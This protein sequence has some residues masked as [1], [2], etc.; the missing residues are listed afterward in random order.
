MLLF[1]DSFRLTISSI[2][3][4]AGVL[5]GLPQINFEFTKASRIFEENILWI[6][7]ALK[8]GIEQCSKED[9]SDPQRGFKK[10]IFTNFH[11][12]EKARE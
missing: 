1:Q 5:L 8:G 2:S 7:I 3:V 6:Y 4:S 10:V 11:E 12:D 9:N